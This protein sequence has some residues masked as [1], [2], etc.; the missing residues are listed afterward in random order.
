MAGA[1]PGVHVCQLKL[2]QVHPDLVMGSKFLKIDEDA[3][4]VCCYFVL[5]K[6]DPKGYIAY[7][8]DVQTGQRDTDY[9]DLYMLRDV[10]TGKSAKIPRDSKV[11]DTC[12]TFGDSV[13]CIEDKTVTVCWGNDFVNL[14]WTSF[15]ASTSDIAKLWCQELFQYAY[16][17]LSINVSVGIFHERAWSKLYYTQQDGKISVKK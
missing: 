13:C 17:L 11:N 6:V 3:S 1:K 9:M 8:K 5:L 4:S 2:P 7:W 15:V 14:Q 10:R 16:N 12:S